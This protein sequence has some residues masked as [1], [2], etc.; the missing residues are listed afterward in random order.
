MCVLIYFSAKGYGDRGLLTIGELVNEPR[1]LRLTQS[2]LYEVLHPG[3]DASLVDVEDLPVITDK[4]DVFHSAVA[5][6]YAPSDG[7]GAR[8]V[9][10]ERIRSTPRPWRGGLPRHDCIVAESDPDSPGFRGLFAARVRCFFKFKYRGVEYP[11]ALVYWLTTVEDDPDPLTGMWIVKPEVDP[12]D[13]RIPSASVIPIDSILRGT[14]LIPAFGFDTVPD[15]E[16]INP[17]NSLDC[18]DSY[19]VNKYAD[20]H[21]HELL[22]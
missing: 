16:I 5:Y 17:S 1:L 18:F 9:T 13:E 6:Y 4:V 2:Y 14:H 11:S 15:D 20:H 19:Y 7:A 10:K 22:Y 8:G 21:S 3:S 12:E